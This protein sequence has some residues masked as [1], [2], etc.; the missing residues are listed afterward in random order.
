M[1]FKTIRNKAV[2]NALF[3]IMKTIIIFDL[4]LLLIEK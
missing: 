1:C 3:F 2:R 4:H